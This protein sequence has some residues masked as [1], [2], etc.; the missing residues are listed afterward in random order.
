[1]APSSAPS[2]TA[3]RERDR[4][5]LDTYGGM[6]FVRLDCD[7]I[8][9]GHRPH[10]WPLPSRRAALQS[11]DP[12][13][14]APYGFGADHLDLGLAAG[15]RGP[16]DGAVPRVNV[17]PS[18]LVLCSRVR[19][20]SVTHLSRLRARSPLRSTFAPTTSREVIHTRAHLTRLRVPT[21]PANAYSRG[22]PVPSCDSSPTDRACLTRLDSWSASASRI[23]C[24]F[25]HGYL[26]LQRLLPVRAALA[27]R[28]LPK[29]AARNP[30]YPPCR[31]PTRSVRLR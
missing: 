24:W 16:I 22:R 18:S 27:T 19:S 5:E 31:F 4:L 17:A 12:V 21:T 1:M 23:S 9:A 7:V 8:Q 6:A 3:S 25:V 30:D 26:S 11:I 2:A 28:R 15:P 20:S 14:L 29:Q 13:D 10:T